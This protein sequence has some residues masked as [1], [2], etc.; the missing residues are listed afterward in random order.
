MTLSSPPHTKLDFEIGDVV[1]LEEVFEPDAFFDTRGKLENWL[2][3][4]QT[5]PDICRSIDTSYG[6]I[7]AELRPLFASNGKDAPLNI[8][9]N[10]I[11][12]KIV[13]L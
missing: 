13:K 12:I 3:V 9:Y 7:M 8:T 10:F 6:G 2:Y 1:L 11:S 4:L 5:R